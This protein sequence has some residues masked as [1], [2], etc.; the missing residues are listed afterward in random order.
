MMEIRVEGLETIEFNPNH[1][2]GKC[3]R[4]SVEILREKPIDFE[5]GID[6]VATTDAPAMVVDWE[7]WRMIR[8]VLPMRYY[9]APQDD[10]TTLLDTHSRVSIEKVKGSA[11]NWTTDDHR[12]FAKVFISETEGNVRKKIEEKHI[13]RVSIGYQTYGENTIEIP[14]GKEIL[15]DGVSYKNDFNDGVPFVVRTKWTPFELSLV[16]IGADQAAKF[17]SMFSDGTIKEKGGVTAEEIRSIIKEEMTDHENKITIN[18]KG[19]NTMSEINLNEEKVLAEQQRISDIDALARDWKDKVKGVN[20]DEAAKL[21]KQSGRSAEKFADYILEYK[22]KEYKEA[23]AK[24]T[25]DMNKKEVESYSLTRAIS[26]LLNGDNCFEL[27]VSAEYARQS[28]RRGDGGKSPSF[29]L[30]HNVVNRAFGKGSFNPT[31][32]RD[33][34]T[35]AT[36]GG[37]F[38]GTDHL[39]AQWID[40]LRNELVLA[41]A[42]VVYLPGRKGN[43]EIPKLSTGNTFG[44]AATENA[45]LTESTPATT[46][47]T[48]SP[49][50]GGT[51]VDISKTAIIQSDPALDMILTMD[52]QAVM[53]RGFDAAGLHGSGAGGQI[54]GIKATS[55]VNSTSLAS[56]QWV[57]ILN[58]IKLI[59]AGN[60]ALS[61][62]KWVTNA[63]G[64]AV[65]AGR[66]KASGYPVYLMDDAGTVARRQVLTSEAVQTTHIFLGAWNQ[67]YMAFWDALDVTV[68][69]YSL[70]TYFQVRIT[71]NQLADFAVRYPGAFYYAA[72]LS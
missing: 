72:D 30:P 15:I 27:E 46:E 70:A 31:M 45:V 53:A 47:V 39:G 29:F 13:K 69:P 40:V 37:E 50:R 49:K 38:V 34:N 9:V 68:D 6:T 5:K 44:W 23:A 32:K 66:E 65:L 71:F 36:T 57:D 7:N 18:Q 42:G 59:K 2:G 19:E 16:P 24:P 14:K 3:S 58:A 10:D 20:L 25:V 54:T 1:F 28:G 26:S 62:L 35:T 61:P 48:L 56:A 67:A 33:V 51:F 63:S 22:E 64:E 4:E 12:L 41:Q 11:R 21:Y 17:R 55:L 43:I 8:E 52:G 60:A